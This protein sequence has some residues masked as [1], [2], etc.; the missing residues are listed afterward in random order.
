MR[1]L[2]FL[3]FLSVV[4]ANPF[5][6]PSPA[7]GFLTLELG[8]GIAVS[9]ASWR[10]PSIS[11]HRLA[12]QTVTALTS[13]DDMLTIYTTN[14]FGDQTT[15]LFRHAHMKYICDT[16]NWQDSYVTVSMYDNKFTVFDTENCQPAQA[17]QH[18]LEMLQA[19][20]N[21]VN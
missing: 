19:A 18:D 20:Y 2:L 16:A 13:R 4:V 12:S 10:G 9:L 6:L 8:T 3:A 11:I 7:N 15:V 5:I 14:Q 21:C 17:T 1:L